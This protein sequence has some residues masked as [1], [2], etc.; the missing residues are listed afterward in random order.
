MVIRRV[1]A[2]S[3]YFFRVATRSLTDPLRPLSTPA[4]GVKIFI[5]KPNGVLA[6]DD[7]AMT[8]ES[9]GI[10]KYTHQTATSD[11]IGVWRVYFKIV[12]T[13]TVMTKEVD[14]FELTP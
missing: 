13:T 6:V 12:G 4:S 8:N 7:T 2:G 9:T 14:A 11:P 1:R 5:R 10:F 3:A